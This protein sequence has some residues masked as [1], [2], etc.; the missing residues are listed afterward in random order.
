MQI[1][2]EAFVD[3]PPQAVFATAADIARW[4]QFISGVE[5]VE[6]LTRGEVGAG[7]RF[8]ET[9]KMFGRQATEEM[10]VAGI[11]PPQRLLLT[12][13]NHGTAYRIEHGFAPEGA[14]TRATLTFEGR[15]Q[16][17]LARAFAPLGLLFM[18]AVKRQ[19]VADLADLA[20]EAERRHGNCHGTAAR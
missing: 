11:A 12:A 10:T 2:V 6:V 14:G 4:P 20:R 1:S 18:G 3:A 17:L 19:L 16:T 9:R 15:P 13:F 7:T 5:A 8:R